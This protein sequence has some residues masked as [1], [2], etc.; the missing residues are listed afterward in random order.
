MGSQGGD[1]E[2]IFQLHSREKQWHPPQQQRIGRKFHL[3]EEP[4]F[5]CYVG[6]F[7]FVCHQCVVLVTRFASPATTTTTNSSKKRRNSPRPSGTIL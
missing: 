6:Y 2:V 1:Q 5:Y 3:E 4:S 7:L